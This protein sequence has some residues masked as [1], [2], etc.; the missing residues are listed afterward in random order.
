[1]PPLL[2]LIGSWFVAVGLA[3]RDAVL[4]F[5][6]EEPDG[7]ALS[8]SNLNIINRDP[9]WD[10]MCVDPLDELHL[11]LGH[12]QQ[13]LFPVNLDTVAL[14]VPSGFFSILFPHISHLI[15]LYFTSVSSRRSTKVARS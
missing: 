6:V 9:A 1:M 15:L 10:R 7:A 4:V 2:W 5:L 8:R 12:L 11:H 13:Y 14:R 3:E